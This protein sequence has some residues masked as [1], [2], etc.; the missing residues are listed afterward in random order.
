VVGGSG[1]RVRL[2]E[3]DEKEEEEEEEEEGGGAGVGVLM[4]GEVDFGQ[5]SS[6]GDL[7]AGTFNG[8]T[9][10]VGGVTDDKGMRT[11]QSHG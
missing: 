6:A 2:A 9:A 4:E 10:Q 3:E 8:K 1:F 7:T 5:I 11:R